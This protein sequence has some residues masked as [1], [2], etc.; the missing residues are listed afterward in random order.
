[1]FVTMSIERHWGHIMADLCYTLKPG[2]LFGLV[3]EMETDCILRTKF[4]KKNWKIHLF[5]SIIS[6]NG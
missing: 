4:S 3:Q 2:G 6:T 1:M 5:S